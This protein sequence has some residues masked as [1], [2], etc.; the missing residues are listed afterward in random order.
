[1]P[2]G[3]VRLT[4]VRQAGQSQLSAQRGRGDEWEP[5]ASRVAPATRAT[6]GLVAPRARARATTRTTGR[7]L[8]IWIQEAVQDHP[9]IEPLGVRVTQC[10][11]L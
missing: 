5:G 9:M 2:G 4:R 10:R 11:D 6:A 1:M 3:E 8:F 7:D